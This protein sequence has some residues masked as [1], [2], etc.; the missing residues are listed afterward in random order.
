M[1][2]H[3]TFFLALL[4]ACTA[5]G[6]GGAPEPTQ[7]EQ[8]FVARVHAGMELI[9]IVSEENRT[10]APEDRALI[11]EMQRS[12]GLRVCEEG[13]HGTTWREDCKLCTCIYGRRSCPP[14]RC[15]HNSKVRETGLRRTRD[16][17]QPTESMASPTAGT[18]EGGE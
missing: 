9:L 4:S 18:E 1:K 14:V 6:P 12:K 11:R 2:D 15:T 16:P 3:K 10:L 17:V 13:E 8:G 7:V 5:Q